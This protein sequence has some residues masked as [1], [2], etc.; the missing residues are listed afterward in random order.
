MIAAPLRVKTGEEGGGVAIVRGCG[1]RR[2][3]P[4]G[5]LTGLTKILGDSVRHPGFFHLANPMRMILDLDIWQWAFWSVGNSL[6][7]ITHDRRREIG[8]Y[9]YISRTSQK[10]SRHTQEQDLSPKPN[11]LYFD[12]DRKRVSGNRSARSIQNEYQLS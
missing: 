4:D 3:D 8:K 10:S 1:G 9:R 12:I 6:H 7:Y 2:L 5:L 11:G